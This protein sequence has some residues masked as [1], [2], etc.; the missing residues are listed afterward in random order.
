MGCLFFVQNEVF[1][2]G[3][4]PK[5]LN[6]IPRMAFIGQNEDFIPRKSPKMNCSLYPKM[7]VIPRL[8]K[9][10]KEEMNI[11]PRLGKSKILYV[12]AGNRP[13]S[14]YRSYP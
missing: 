7:N 11:I 13:T 14:I 12:V 2:S 6:I 10:L 9:R 4:S 1:T 3:I 8:K 5:K